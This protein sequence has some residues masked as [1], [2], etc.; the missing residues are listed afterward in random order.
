M[1]R[2]HTLCDIFNHQPGLKNILTEVHKLLKIYLTIPVTT[3]SAER[4]FSALKRIK[5][6]LRNSMTQER[7]NHCMLLHMHREK[8]DNL[9]LIEI[10][11]E[12]VSRCER[13]KNFLN[14]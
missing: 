11:K 14:T 12:F 9:D 10:A 3:S 4:S 5:D 6:Y 8:T 7:L 13:R 2:V 1:T